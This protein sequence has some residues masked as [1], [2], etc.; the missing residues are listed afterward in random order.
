MK[1]FM[2]LGGLIGFGIGVSAGLA[3]DRA[4]PDILWRASVGA[5]LAGVVLRWWGRVWV[6]C[7]R[8]SLRERTARANAGHTASA[9][10]Q[11]KV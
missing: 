4:W 7:F 6:T 8:D 11:L 1:L 3:Q 5:L 2:I 9:P 10:G